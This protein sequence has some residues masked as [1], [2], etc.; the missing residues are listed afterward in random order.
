MVDFV[1]EDFA[2]SVTMGTAGT[3][4]SASIPSLDASAVA[5]L[6]VDLDNMKDVFQFQTDSTDFVNTAATD[7]KYLVQMANWPSLNPSNAMMDHASSTNPIA[8]TGSDGSTLASNKMMVCHDFTRYLALK[9]FS[10]HFGVDLFNNEPELLQNLR[11]VTGASSSGQTWY[12]INASLTAVSTTGD[13]T[14]IVT[15]DASGNFMTNAQTGN[16]NI[17][18]SLFDQLMGAAPSR[19]SG[20]GN[21][22]TF[23]SIPFAADDT[24]S[25]KLT[26]APAT[27]QHNLTGVSAIGNRVYKIKL[28]MKASP[29]N[30]AVDSNEE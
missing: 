30:T 17:C 5:V 15:G 25:F 16:T 29:S 13:H 28:I 21:S 12:D 7:L 8:T 6:E 23:Q 24:I 2:S 26:V 11:T 1:L 14:G 18:K 10:T 4:A 22:G 19:F 27:N 3:L 20:L 9:L